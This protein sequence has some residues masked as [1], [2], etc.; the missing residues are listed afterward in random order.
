M[1]RVTLR[2]RERQGGKS[3]FYLDFYSNGQRKI[4][5]LGLW[6]YNTPR[7][8]M[9]KQHN[10]S[11]TIQAEREEAKYRQQLNI[12]EYG[13]VSGMIEV[14]QYLSEI[15]GNVTARG[16]IRKVGDIRVSKVNAAYVQQIIDY[17]YNHES[18]RKHRYVYTTIRDVY[19]SIR[20]SIRDY[21][22]KYNMII[23]PQIYNIVIK[24][25]VT[26]KTTID[27]LSADQLSAI[28]NIYIAKPHICINAFLFA[29]YTGLRV[30]DIMQLHVR[31]IIERNERKYICLTQ[32]KTRNKVM[33]PLSTMALSLMPEPNAQGMY[34][35]VTYRQISWAMKRLG[36]VI[37][38]NLHFHMA[39][40]TFATLLVKK[41]S[42]YTVSKLLGHQSIQTT[43]VYADIDDNDKQIAVDS[44]PEL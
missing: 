1:E 38:V 4:K 12:S 10:K 22:R 27:V 23:D 29:C 41:T 33:I 15:V 34:Y 24:R 28:Y 35:P 11:V 31:N 8:H 43:Q 30:S 32:Q 14:S 40:H 19:H 13:Y 44:M 25:P 7:T 37:G 18:S 17:M 2:L 6:V 20:K 26:D 42:L 9:E 21:C 39:R 36:A 3:Y 5:S 16:L